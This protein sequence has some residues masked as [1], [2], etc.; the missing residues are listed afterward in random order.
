MAGTKWEGKERKA[1][2]AI[3]E[4]HN[5]RGRKGSVKCDNVTPQRRVSLAMCDVISINEVCTKLCF[6][7]REEIIIR[8]IYF[9]LCKITLQNGGGVA[10][11]VT[12]F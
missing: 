1:G 10:H 9:L 7:A 4:V 3:H 8:P 2:E 5:A 12:Y 11:D 6:H